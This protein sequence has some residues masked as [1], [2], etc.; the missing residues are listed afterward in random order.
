M[1]THEQIKAAKASEKRTKLKL[2]KLIDKS[3]IKI[4]NLE[5]KLSK[6]FSDDFYGAHLTDIGET[7]WDLAN[8]WFSIL[9]DEFSINSFADR[10]TAPGDGNPNL[11][12]AW[13]SKDNGYQYRGFMPD[14]IGDIILNDSL[15]F[16]ERVAQVSEIYKMCRKLETE[17]RRKKINVG[18]K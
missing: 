11:P 18:K 6:T 7:A 16:S 1:K 12:V 14:T 13:W 17:H 8:T 5:F 4:F 9:T 15:H 3:M 10:F 2:L